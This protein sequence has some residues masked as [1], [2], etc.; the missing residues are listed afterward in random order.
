MWLLGAGAP[1]AAGIRTAWDMT[2]EFKQQLYVSQ[3][4]ISQKIVADLANPTVRRELQSFTD[5][6]GNL[7][8]PGAPDEYAALFEAAYL[9]KTDQIF[10]VTYSEAASPDLHSFEDHRLETI[11]PTR[12][13]S[14][15]DARRT[16][17]RRM[18]D[19]FR[20]VDRRRLHESL[21]RNGSVDYGGDRDRRSRTP[22]YRRESLA[23]RGQ[24]ARRLPIAQA[25]D[26]R[27][28]IA[29]TERQAQALLVDSPAD[30]ASS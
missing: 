29:R 12:R 19:Q 5:G 23:R 21:R 2:W 9:S 20:P 6:I 17:P 26:Y 28:R 13:A 1:A 30:G 11:L 3:R 8:S 18:D 25:K 24:T 10:H 22:S 15:V 16:C 4:R 14:D 27:R 7:P